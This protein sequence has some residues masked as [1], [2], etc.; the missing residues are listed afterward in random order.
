MNPF[1]LFLLTLAVTA[2]ATPADPA[3][4]I[5]ARKLPPGVIEL[6]VADLH[7]KTCAKKL[8]RRLYA[9][10]GVRRVRPNVAKDLVTIELVPKKDVD[11][12]L[13]WRAAEA[14]EQTPIALLVAEHKLVAKDF[15]KPE[16]KTAQRPAA[17]RAH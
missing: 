11:L 5:K 8:A 1:A 10:P 7:C 2:P 12:A 15:P 4:A 13:L 9:T 16:G 6:H 17:P 14:A 3:E